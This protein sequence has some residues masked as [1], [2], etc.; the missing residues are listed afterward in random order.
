MIKKV[1]LFFLAILACFLLLFGMPFAVFAKQ[2]K[3]KIIYKKKTIINFEDNVVQGE[4]VKPKGVY[5]Q[6][7]G[8]AKFNTL[9]IYRKSFLK[10]M[11][12]QA[13]KL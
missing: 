5:Y 9:I 7:R 2:N 10:E 4:L 12:R 6:S 8:R 13:K 11:F 1:Y 3:T